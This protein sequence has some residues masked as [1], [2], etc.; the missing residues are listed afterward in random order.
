[1]VLVLVLGEESCVYVSLG[2]LGFL[3]GVQFSDRQGFGDFLE[4]RNEGWDRVLFFSG[5][6]VG[7]RGEGYVL[8][9]EIYL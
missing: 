1:M 5:F 9:K 6:L 4:L 2:V 8:K 7:R 3:R